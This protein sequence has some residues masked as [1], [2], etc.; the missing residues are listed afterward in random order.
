[1]SDAAVTTLNELSDMMTVD[2]CDAH[3]NACHVTQP[4]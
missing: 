2:A 1:M 3:A 4:K